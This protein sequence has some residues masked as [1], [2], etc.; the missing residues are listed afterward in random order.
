[1]V[2]YAEHMLILTQ[3][4]TKNWYDMIPTGR[5]LKKKKKKKGKK[6]KK[7]NKYVKKRIKEEKKK[8]TANNDPKKQVKQSKPDQFDQTQSC[9]STPYMTRI[10]KK[11]KAKVTDISTEIAQRKIM[12]ML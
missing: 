6:V 10:W 5:E 1:M 3:D 9:S 8:K 11:K 7:R 12:K 2:L 4:S